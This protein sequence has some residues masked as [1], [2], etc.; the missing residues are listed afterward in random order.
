MTKP[1]FIYRSKQFSNF[2]FSLTGIGRILF[3]LSIC[4]SI[5]PVSTG[6]AYAESVRAPSSRVSPSKPVR[7]N[8]NTSREY[9]LGVGDLIKIQVHGEPDL[10]LETRLV[11]KGTIT[12]PFLGEIRV[13]GL[14]VLR[15]REII[16]EGLRGDYLIEP[17]VQVTVI[18]YRPFY[19]N[20][21][22][23]RPGGYPYVPGLTARKAAALAGGLTERASE[24]K[25]FVL[26]END[27]T[28]KR[29][30]IEMDTNVYP[31]DIM[32]IE[33]GLF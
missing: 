15:L 23:R 4:A 26:R 2:R 12:Y 1:R 21:E 5:V 24:N 16:T 14:S 20:G 28:N 29:V 19:V 9:L 25:I 32:I 33:E 13:I 10:G 27:K 11:E 18:E 31:G 3:W 22:V 6:V 17:E 30:K 8:N 7:Q